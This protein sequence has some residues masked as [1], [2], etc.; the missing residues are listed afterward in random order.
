MR[1]YLDKPGGITLEDCASIS[2]QLSDLLDVS[3][4]TR[5]AYSLEVSSPGPNRPLG[6]P[7]DFE[8]YKG[9]KGMI[10]AAHAIGGRKNF[11]GILKGVIDNRVI[12]QTDEKTV[13]IPLDEIAKARRVAFLASRTNTFLSIPMLM[14]M[15]G[16]GHGGF[17][18]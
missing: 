6:T 17:F 9:C 14:S 12:L 3:F 16:Y 7:A 15:V 10:R 8:T 1:V 13:E 5:G 4:E 11:K 2:R 18:I